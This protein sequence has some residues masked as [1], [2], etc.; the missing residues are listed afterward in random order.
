MPRLP[1][2]PAVQRSQAVVLGSGMKVR[3]A[4]LGLLWKENFPLSLNSEHSGF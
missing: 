4:H 3:G 1:G 2:Q